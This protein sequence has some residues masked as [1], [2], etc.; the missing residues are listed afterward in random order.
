MLSCS[1]SLRCV[2]RINVRPVCVRCCKQT[3]EDAS[4]GQCRGRGTSKIQTFYETPKPGEV[5]T[6]EGNPGNSNGGD[7]VDVAPPVPAPEDEE[8]A[9]PEAAKTSPHGPVVQELDMMLD[10][11]TDR[12]LFQLGT[13]PSEL[14]SAILHHGPF[15]P[16]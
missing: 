15:R 5:E 1:T 14:R 8:A 11:P 12:G 9:E 7:A 6:T 10:N 4:T 16:K 13:S 2:C 3:R